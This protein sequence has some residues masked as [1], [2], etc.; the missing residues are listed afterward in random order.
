MRSRFQLIHCSACAHIKLTSTNSP[1]PPQPPTP[2][3]P[4]PPFSRSVHGIRADYR[5]PAFLRVPKDHPAFLFATS[6]YMD[7]AQWCAPDIL[8]M[9]LVGIF[10][11]MQV[12]LVDSL[13]AAKKAALDTNVRAVSEYYNDGVS[14]FDSFSSLLAKINMLTG[15][16]RESLMRLMIVCIKKNVIDD[17]LHRMRTVEC[18]E[19]MARIFTTVRGHPDVADRAWLKERLLYVMNLIKV[20]FTTQKRNWG[21]PKF[22]AL[23]HLIEFLLFWGSLSN[24]SM[25]INEAYH[26]FAKLDVLHSN[27]SA[28]VPLTVALCRASA[29]RI[30]LARIFQLCHTVPVFQYL[31]PREN[32]V[33]RPLEH[34][35]STQLQNQTVKQAWAQSTAPLLPS[36]PQFTYF[37][38]FMHA[39][40]IDGVAVMDA[41]VSVGEAVRLTEDCKSSTPLFLIDEVFTVKNLE[42]I[43]LLTR[44]LTASVP[45][46]SLVAEAY[47]EAL[48]T[49][50]RYVQPG[51]YA[52]MKAT[53]VWA[54][55]YTPIAL[56]S[57]GTIVRGAYAFTASLERAG[58]RF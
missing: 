9:F 28:T 48:D 25:S 26:K 27:N 41:S 32:L 24:V 57:E 47:N 40:A 55:V 15:R 46:A 21:F 7:Y 31:L 10:K 17:D 38:K 6:E 33:Q 29:R 39:R 49:H 18:F 30:L 4:P 20:T 1:P 51:T 45:I 22:H 16:G 44:Q 8:H 14:T 43:F 35:Y 52:I 11:H 13:S 5:S 12:T 56:T 54:K 50:V 58:S 53:D 42:G 23:H 3:F 34:K 19:S 36:D 37:E 2:P